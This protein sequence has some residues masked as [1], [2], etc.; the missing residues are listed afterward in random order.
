M[1]VAPN[2]RLLAG[3]VLLAG[4]AAGLGLAV[5]LV[6]LDGSIYTLGELKRIGLPV[7]GVM[8]DAEPPRRAA[9]T[10]AF[11]G[12]IALLLLTYG[13]VVTGGRIVARFIA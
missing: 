1:P 3:G 13:G 12:A 4:L 7:L 6:Q 2:R 10:A 8:S 11:A 5:L 9:D